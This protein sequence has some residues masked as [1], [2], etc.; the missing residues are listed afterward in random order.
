MTGI[1]VGAWEI[2]GDD[3]QTVVLG[4][5]RTAFCRYTGQ[6]ASDCSLQLCGPHFHIKAASI[7]LPPLMFK[8][9]IC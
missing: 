4:L 8:A 9:H 6:H 5:H 3:P 2:W 1:V 7:H